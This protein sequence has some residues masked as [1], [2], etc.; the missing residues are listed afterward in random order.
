MA[1]IAAKYGKKCILISGNVI[2]SEE[3]IASSG[4][5]SCHKTMLPDDTVEIAMKNAES[6]LSECVNRLDLR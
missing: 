4:F 3:E 2:L 6:R 1:N 5:A